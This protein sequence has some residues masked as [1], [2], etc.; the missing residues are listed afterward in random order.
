MSRRCLENLIGRRPHEGTGR[1]SVGIHEGK[2]CR[3]NQVTTRRVHLISGLVLG[4]ANG[5][6][7]LGFPKSTWV[8]LS[9]GTF[10][11][12]Q[13]HEHGTKRISFSRLVGIGR[14]LRY[15]LADPIGDLAILSLTDLPPKA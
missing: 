1:D 13:K 5:A 7:S 2:T 3:A 15:N 11:Q 12:M 6:W 4:C 9:G 10:Q 14:A 8:R